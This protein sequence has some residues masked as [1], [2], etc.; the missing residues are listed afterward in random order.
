VQEL[1]LP[2]PIQQILSFRQFGLDGQEVAK[3]CQK[4]HDTSVLSGARRHE[5]QF[6]TLPS[7][8]R[9]DG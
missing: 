5:W 6:C 8:Y 1:L 4:A 7:N 3:S 9:H 2:W